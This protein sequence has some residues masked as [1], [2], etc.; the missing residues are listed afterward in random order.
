MEFIDVLK[1]RS[2]CRKFSDKVVSDDIISKIL[3]A[4]N[5]A[6]TAKNRQPQR[7]YVIKSNEGLSIIDRASRCRYNAPVCILVCSCKDEAHE[8]L[9]HSTYEMDAVICA[10][11]MML[12][13]T[14]L[15]ID[16]IW[17][18]LF[19]RDIISKSFNLPSNII[20][21]MLMP[22]GYKSDDCLG[23]PMHNVRK[24]INDIVT[25]L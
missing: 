3:D 20:P 2:A 4:G 22:I 11:H 23:N 16:N 1:K 13:A 7:I 9:G 24:D 8:S 12:S 5:L 25:F 14:D 17:I 21:V 15:G 19:D 6:P 10:T 18:E